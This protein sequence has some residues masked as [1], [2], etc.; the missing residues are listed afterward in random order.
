VERAVTS[1]DDAPLDRTDRMILGHLAAV[2]E[3]LDQPPADLDERVRFA[4]AVQAV[5][6]EVARLREDA[7]VGSGAR[8]SERTRTITFDAASRTVMISIAVRPDDTVRLDG[9]LGPAAVLRIELRLA[10]PATSL[11]VTCDQAGRFVF[12]QVPRGLVQL[13]VHPPDPGPGPGGGGAPDAA[14][15]VVTPS[16][17]L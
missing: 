11:V 10:G 16:I 12:D 9:W 2:H 3:V 8:G 4:I 13:L 17:V 5:D 7:L 1:G 15:P 6:L 14:H